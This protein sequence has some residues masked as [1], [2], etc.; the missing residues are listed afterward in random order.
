VLVKKKSKAFS[1]IGLFADAPTVESAQ[2]VSCGWFVDQMSANCEIP[3][4]SNPA[5]SVV[6]ITKGSK[7]SIIFV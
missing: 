3:F 2:E 6:S 7:E 4:Y 1:L 5:P